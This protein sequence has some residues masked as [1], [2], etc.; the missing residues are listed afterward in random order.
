MEFYTSVSSTNQKIILIGYRD[1]KKFIERLNFKPTMGLESNNES[2]WKSLHGGV[3]LEEKV[4]K[5]PGEYRKYFRDYNSILSLHSTISPEQQFIAKKY[6]EKTEFDF[7]KIR[8]F[9]IDIEVDSQGNGFPL[10]DEAKWPITSI[11]IKDSYGDKYYVLSTKKYNPNKTVLDLDP[12]KIFFK[13]CKDEV[14]L[15]VRFIKLMRDLKPDVLV[16]WYSNGFDYPY[17]INRSFALLKKEEVL[18]MSPTNRVSVREGFKEGKKVFYCNIGG[19]TLLDYIEMYKKYTFTPREMYSLDFI[20]EEELGENKIDYSEY[21]NL[22]DL[23]NNNPQK[24]IDY[25]IYDVELI[26]KIDIELGL[27]QLHCTVAYDVGCNIGDAM[28]PVKLWDASFYYDLTK[29]GIMVPPIHVKDSEEIPGAH[30]MAPKKGKYGWLFSVDLNS[31]YPHLIQQFNISPE[32]L[33]D[34]MRLDVLQRNADGKIVINDGFL[35]QIIKNNTNFIMA[36]NG[37]FFRRDKEGFVSKTMKKV[38]SERKIAKKEMLRL[39]QC[40]EDEKTKKYDTKIKQLDAIQMSKKIRLNSCYGAMANRYF[41]YM[42]ERLASAITLSGQLANR[43]ISNYIMNSDAA[44]KYEISIIYQDTDSDYFS[45]EELVAK[46]LKK[47][48]NLTDNQITDQIDKFYKKIIDPIIQEG[49]ENLREYVNAVENRMFMSREIIAKCFHPKTVI[50]DL[51]INIEDLYNSIDDDVLVMNDTEIKYLDIPIKS[52]NENIELEL[53]DSIYAISRK[54][55]DGYMYK[56]EKDGEFIE[57]TENHLLAVKNN[58][59]FEWK[60]AKDIKENDVLFMIGDQ[61]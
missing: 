7:S 56:F 45:V 30:V 1:G 16:G 27:M 32:C 21:D 36:G 18:K 14:E 28:S 59:K 8:V 46:M 49:Y 22:T 57:V 10:P 29:E 38:Y 15:L 39:E 35:N 23:W 25:N 42:D 48:P 55:Y 11:A 60:K 53:D 31:L 13:Y 34:G 3:N 54:K 40:R 58:D 44:K 41:R 5:N 9:K 51:G 6:G 24:Y 33:I 2:E 20:A 52:I 61:K 43:W 47:K 37:C 4:F 12:K 19:V 50:S 17:L 26:D